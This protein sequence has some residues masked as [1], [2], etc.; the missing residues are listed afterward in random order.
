MVKLPKILVQC[1]HGFSNFS[2]TLSPSTFSDV[3]VGTA[4]HK[5]HQS[6]CIVSKIK[7]CVGENGLENTVLLFT[8]RCKGKTKI[9]TIFLSSSS[10]PEGE[11]DT[12][13]V[14]ATC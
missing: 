8:H 11:T 7:M 5:S 3:T 1:E 2:Q 13:L 14:I 9:I 12:R 10:F 6:S 4:S